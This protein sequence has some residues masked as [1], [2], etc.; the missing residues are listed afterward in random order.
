MGTNTSSDEVGLLRIEVAALNELLEVHEKVV[1]EQS[2]KLE[3]AFRE[4]REEI[5]LRKK[6]ITELEK[7][8][9]VM[10]LRAH[11]KVIELA[12]RLMPEVPVHLIGDPGRLRQVL[13]NLVGNAIKFTERGDVVL[14]VGLAGPSPG[15]ARE[16]EQSTL[17]FSIKDTGIGIPPEKLDY[18]F[19]KFT[20]AD[21]STTR[22]YGGTGLGLPITK[23]LVELM[24]GGYRSRASRARAALFPLPSAWPDNRSPKSHKPSRSPTLGGSGS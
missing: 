22:H 18:I 13:T 9:E 4:L 3:Q 21:N 24:G 7:A 6:T 12:C 1:S 15:L 5:E 16:S 17:L 19:E 10:A 23:R 2:A 20:Q 8:G 14:E 11:E